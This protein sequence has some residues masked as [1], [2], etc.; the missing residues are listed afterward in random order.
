MISLLSTFYRNYMKF[1]GCM[2]DEHVSTCL[3]LTHCHKHTR[4]IE[5]VII[6]RNYV[7]G[8]FTKKYFQ[9][10]Y[11]CIHYDHHRRKKCW[12]KRKRIWFMAVQL[13]QLLL[14][15]AQGRMETEEISSL[16]LPLDM[17]VAC[18]TYVSKLILTIRPLFYEYSSHFSYSSY[19]SGN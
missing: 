14:Y 13:P 5:K 15:I 8:P 12:R 9:G 2:P 3:H 17:T 16:L 6:I 10:P 1:C 7:H 18:P 4:A 19:L 11:Q